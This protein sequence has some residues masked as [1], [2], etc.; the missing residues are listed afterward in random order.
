MLIAVLN[1]MIIAHFFGT[2]REIEIFFATNVIIYVVMKLSQA[3]EMS[4]IILP[5]YHK[6]KY[7]VNLVTA[8]RVVSTVLNWYAIALLALSFIVFMIAPWLVKVI[9]PGFE[10]TDHI[11]GTQMIRALSPLLAVMFLSGQIQTLINAEKNFGV[12][13]AIGVASRIILIITIVVGYNY[14]SVWIMIIS[15]W[16]STLLNFFLLL[17]YYYWAGNWHYFQLTDQRV[18]VFPIVKKIWSTLPYVGA[19]QIWAI[20]FNAGLSTLP[21][22]T[23]AIFTYSRTLATKLSSV[24]L[25]PMSLVFFTHFSEE[26]SKKRESLN[27]ITSKALEYIPLIIVPSIII[28]ILAGEYILGFLWYGDKFGLNSIELSSRIVTILLLMLLIE[29]LYTIA[30]K[31]VMSLGYVRLTYSLLSISQ[32]LT[33][34]YAFPAIR[35]WGVTGAISSIIVNMLLLTMVPF[36]VLLLREK[37]YL[38][39]YKFSTSLK[40]ILSGGLTY[41]VLSIL[42]HNIANLINLQNIRLN[43][44]F[45][46]GITSI[47]AASITLGFAALFNIIIVKTLLQKIIDRVKLVF[48]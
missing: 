40:W 13:E 9:V 44:M 31:I 24:F 22:G 47:M 1:T 12:P 27:T 21:G 33:A 37:K 2:S 4:E 3:G 43:F 41:I 17:S 18:S 29:G 6:F 36:I 45:N 16:V 39:F 30:R 28:F 25:R 34:C 14:F 48:V 42:N 8:Q 35:Y 11:L 19:T 7:D 38:F 46:A 10:E 23:L 26:Y 5:I 20:V 32:I 15:L